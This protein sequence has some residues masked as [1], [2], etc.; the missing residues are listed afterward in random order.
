MFDRAFRELTGY[1]PMPWQAA[2]YERCV[3]GDFPSSC[4]LPTG[5]G[6]TSIIHIWLIALAAAPTQVPRRLVY[7]VNRRTVVDQATREAEN[8]R[9]NLPKTPA[10]AE[11]LRRLCTEK[12]ELPLAIS[13]LRGQFA[14]NGEWAADP[15]RPAIVVG[16]VD[17]IGSRLLFSGYGCGF[18]SRPLHAGFLGQDVLLV[19]DEA[20]LEPAFQKL[21][22]RIQGEQEEGERT[23]K[24]PWP[25]LRVMAL[26]AT[27]REG[28][29]EAPCEPFE[30]T[31][32][33]KQPPAKIPDPP[34]EPIH[35]VWRRLRATKRLRL[36]Q[37]EDDAKIA[38]EIAT[39][40]LTYKASN[41]AVL[42]F[43][44][45]PDDVAKV[46]S[47]LT[48]K[49]DGVPADQ[50]QKLT[51]TMRGFERDRL[52]R[53]DPVFA[54]FLPPKSRTSGV[55]LKEGTV[56]LVCTSAGEVGIDISADHMVCDLSTFESMAQRLGRVNRYGDCDDTWI[57]VV[58]PASFG[59]VDKKSGELKADEIDKR[60]QK[61]LDL[62]RRLPE[63]GSQDKSGSPVY[64]ASPKALGDLRQCP[65]LPCR[66]EDAFSPEPGMPFA[67]DVL[68][69]AWALT[70]I[71][72]KM[73]GRP[74][75][76]PYLHGIADWQPPETYVAWR[77]EVARIHGDFLEDY[78]PADLLDDYPLKPHE[79]L[80]DRSDRVFAQLQ[81]LANQEADCPIWVVDDRTDVEVTTLKQLIGELEPLADKRREDRMDGSTI[82]LPPSAGGLAD[83]MLD[84]ASRQADDVADEATDQQGRKQR[85]RVWDEQAVPG[86]LRLLRTIDTRPDA[87]E[88]GDDSPR[89][90]FWH[91]YDLAREGGRSSTRPVTWDTHANDVVCRARRIVEALS[92]P[93][94]IGAA[95]ILAARLHDHG[96]CREGFQLALGNRHFPKV[97]LAKAGR[98]GARLPEPFRHEFAAVLDA[99]AD[100]EFAGLGDEMQDLVLHLVAAHHGRARP[101]FPQDE[102]FD[103]DGPPSDAAA[104]AAETPRRFAR[105]QRRYGRWGLAYLESLLRAADWA[106][107]AAPSA[108]ADEE[109]AAS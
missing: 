107:S 30:L 37:A 46:C 59:K 109:G 67:T 41:A 51:G 9:G 92:L 11:K 6:K 47:R 86:H 38:E 90:R 60:R 76:E 2:L 108:Y 62:L 28:T 81:A 24:M 48:N 95:V 13:T 16:T 44:R 85:Q 71:R 12:S 96:K 82:L 32:E 39:L 79:L 10:L 97:T 91:W 69:D 74:P 78:R 70:T 17:M 52:A 61:T 15:A 99:R 98:A 103:P 93:P 21:I 64:D 45:T 87:D 73:P 5:M 68:F 18:K 83:G 7:V 4:C 63:I 23:S 57:D 1:D 84:G 31:D 22:E 53:V 20:H 65:D 72:E 101:H 104:L 105:L 26:S 77:E 40:A 106:A 3:K 8:L 88:S 19:H 34:K 43:V 14:D 56:F 50:V 49:K 35:H 100:S 58:H 54:R 94:E 75:V 27:A 36:R 66:I 42:V 102:V 25:K 33:E 29:D 89:K 55:I 80:R